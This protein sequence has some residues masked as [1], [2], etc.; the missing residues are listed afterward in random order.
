MLLVWGSPG[1]LCC[2]FEQDI[3]SAALYWFNPGHPVWTWLNLF[4]LGRKD[5]KQTSVVGTQKT[6]LNV[7]GFFEHPNMFKSMGKK[8]MTILCSQFCF[9]GPIIWEQQRNRPWG[10]KTFSCSTQL[11][12]KFPLLM[13]TKIP[14]NKEVSCV[15][16]L[17]CCIFHANKC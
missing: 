17:R 10:Y 1:S 16:S 15:K 14:T 13:K 8:I 3:L 11:S 7:D 9:T 6:C 5:S 12:T 2:V 4:W